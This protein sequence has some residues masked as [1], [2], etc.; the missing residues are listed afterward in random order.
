VNYPGLPTHPQ[1]A[2]AAR[3]FAGR[4]FGGMLS[5]EISGAGKQEVYRFMES[6]QLCLPATTLGD[7]YTLVLH[8][9]TSSHRSLTPLER[10]RVGIADNLVRLSAGIEA[11]EDIISDLDQAL[12]SLP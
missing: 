3:L 2:I 7:I 1:H 8:P 11:I 10:Q 4:G 6:L 9:A 5:F 12:S